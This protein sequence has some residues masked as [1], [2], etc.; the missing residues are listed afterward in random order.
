MVIET[1]NKEIIIRISNTIKK[2]NIQN[3]INVLQY[4]ELINKSKA[5]QKDVD[6]LISLVKRERKN[7]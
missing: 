3:L 2:K 1:T 4:N 5:K 7:K 6:D